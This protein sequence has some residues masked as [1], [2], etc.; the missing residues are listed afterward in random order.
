MTP[1][2]VGPLVRATTATGTVV[3]AEFFQPGEVTLRVTPFD[4]TENSTILLNT[5]TV[6]VGGR[7]YAAPQL[8]GLQPATWYSYRIDAIPGKT[9]AH[10][11]QLAGI[12]HQQVALPYQCFRT[13]DSGEAGEHSEHKQEKSLL[14]AYGSRRQL[15]RAKQEALGAFGGWLIRHFSKKEETYPRPLLLLG[16]QN[17][18]PEPSSKLV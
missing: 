5:H 11:G 7:H 13:L 8:T 9:A 15:T 17:Y 16:D 3:W 18:P 4:A 1:L 10:S 12:E 6:T 2:C 14:L